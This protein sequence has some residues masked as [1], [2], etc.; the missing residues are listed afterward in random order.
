MNK[1]SILAVMAATAAFG[2]TPAKADLPP[3]FLVTAEAPGVTNTTATFDYVGVEDFNGRPQGIQSFA[4]TFGGSPIT[5]TY[6]G[7][8]V[9]PFNQYGGA[10]NSGQYAVS[11]ISQSSSYVIDFTQTGSSGINYFGYWLSALDGGNSVEFWNAGSLLGSFSPTNVLSYVSGNSAY[12]GNPVTGQ[13][14]GEPY[15]FLNFYNTTGTFDRIV[16]NQT[17]FSA[18]YESDNH[19]IGF[20]RTIGGD[21]VDGVPEPGTWAL[22]FLGFGAIGMM[23]R[24]K[25]REPRIALKYA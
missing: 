16:F 11:G 24:A 21:P 3:N 22:M 15:V 10:G 9:I 23:L 14:A 7:V 17:V 1:K 8:N 19:T 5:G 4:S 13:N 18:G 6:N 2:A 12:Y 25:R 20:Y